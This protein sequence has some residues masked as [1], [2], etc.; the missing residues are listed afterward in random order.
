MFQIL[1]FA[2]FANDE[3]FKA[4]AA[5]L[6]ETFFKLGEKANILLGS[7]PPDVSEPENAVV[8]CPVGRRKDGSVDA[9]GHE[10]GF[11]SGA[12][13]E[14]V[15]EFLVG[16]ED[17]LRHLVVKQGTAEDVLLGKAGYAFRDG[18]GHVG[19]GKDQD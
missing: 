14:D 13:D 1:S 5:R 12:V 10:V 6:E 9:A 2:A 11:A 19:K 17:P 7:Q 16:G 3:E 15:P 4:G 8:H 18:C